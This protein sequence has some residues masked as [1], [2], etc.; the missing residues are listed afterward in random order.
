MIKTMQQTQQEYFDKIFK[1]CKHS[2]PRTA[3]MLNISRASVYRFLTG[4]AHK[5]L[6]IKPR[7]IQV[8]DHKNYFEL[9]RGI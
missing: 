5:K 8:T 9:P 1:L 7:I 2:I 4:N 3:R 6:K